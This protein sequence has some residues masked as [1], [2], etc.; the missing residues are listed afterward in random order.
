MVRRRLTCL[1]LIAIGLVLLA[2][3]LGVFFFQ[4]LEVSDQDRVIRYL[5]FLAPLRATEIPFRIPT[6]LA[7]AS[8]DF[9]TLLTPDAPTA[10]PT[11]LSV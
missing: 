10:T 1:A 2:G 6:P 11:P 9:L 3:A 4:R 5:P 7:T 8:F